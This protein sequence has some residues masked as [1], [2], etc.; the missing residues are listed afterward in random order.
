MV[1]STV[2]L[3]VSRVLGISFLNFF[4]ISSFFGI[5]VLSSAYFEAIKVDSSR[6]F[7]LSISILRGRK[8]RVW[9]FCSPLAVSMCVFKGFLTFLLTCVKIVLMLNRWT[10][11]D[12]R[13]FSNCSK[14]VIL[15]T[16][17]KAFDVS[18]RKRK[19]L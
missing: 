13:S 8:W 15:F 7:F 2:R 10:S 6:F 11:F 14:S 19:I 4:C 18:N 17:V 5:Y 16:M 9:N 12:L 3:C 1:L